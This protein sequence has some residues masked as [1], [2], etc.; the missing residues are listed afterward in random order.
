MKLKSQ[1]TIRALSAYLFALAAAFILTE[2]VWGATGG[3]VCGLYMRRN[4]VYREKAISFLRERGINPDSNSAD[5]TKSY[6]SLSE[7]DKR[8]YMKIAKELAKEAIRYV[9]WFY[10]TF[11]VSAVVFGLV[12]FLGG[13]FARGWLLAGA[14]PALSF[15]TNNPLI[16]FGMAKGIS[17]FQKVIVVI[18]AQFAVCYLLAYCGA[19]LGCKRQQKKRELANKAV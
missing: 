16:R 17:T 5:L 9:N 13:L 10:M 18:L 3:A 11:F 4:P 1:F 15:L 8:E 19:R 2:V 7:E 6:Q 12:G 14:V